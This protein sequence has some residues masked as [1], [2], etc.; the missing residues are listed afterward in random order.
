VAKY[1]EIL[2]VNLWP[3]IVSHYPE[4]NYIFQDD[5]T[6]VQRA[7]SVQDYKA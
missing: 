2:E 5:N 6:P 3:L 1:I 4:E 7:R